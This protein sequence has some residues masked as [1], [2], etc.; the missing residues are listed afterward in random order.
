M[1]MRPVWPRSVK[2]KYSI[3]ST[4]MEFID[5][6]IG[7]EHCTWTIPAPAFLIGSCFFLDQAYPHVVLGLTFSHYSKP[8]RK[9]L[10]LMPP[11]TPLP[12]SFTVLT[13]YLLPAT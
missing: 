7:A 8:S 5:I 4:V 2:G 3:S 12:L 10:G 13:K 9:T 6:V 1:G 11:S